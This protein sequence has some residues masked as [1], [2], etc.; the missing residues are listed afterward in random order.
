MRN[1]TIS[2][3]L[4][5]SLASC[6]A[7]GCAS[8]RH[9][10]IPPEAKVVAQG[11]K[12]ITWRASEDGTIYVFDKSAQ[13]MLYS[14]RLKRDE[15]LRIDAMRDQ[16]TLDGRVVNDDK[17]RDHDAINIFFREEPVRDRINEVRPGDATIIREREIRTEPRSD[18]TITVQPE[19]DRVTV[20]GGSDSKVTI[21]QPDSDSKVT[22]E[23]SGERQ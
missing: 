3:A 6:L 8:E 10:D 4:M 14:G 9:R 15:V 23:R 12:D 1:Q 11:Q 13:A 21:E 5:G 17:I 19:R 7:V 22:I 20:E 18:G 2:I 16:I